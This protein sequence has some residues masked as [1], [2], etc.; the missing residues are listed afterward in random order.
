[1]TLAHT[2]NR[3]QPH[4]LAHWITK[5]N[6]EAKIRMEAAGGVGK[7]D[8][9][10]KSIAKAQT[11]KMGQRVLLKMGGVGGA[12]T[13]FQ[14]GRVARVRK[15]ITYDVQLDSGGELEIE[16]QPGRLRARAGKAGAPGK[17]LAAAGGGGVLAR[18]AT[19]RKTGGANKAKARGRSPLSKS[20]R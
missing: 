15:N 11:F 5:Q 14:P 17:Q 7:H 20:K 18:P 4:Q 12:K 9:A 6:A 19:G 16:V 3:C 8:A 10:K 13:V 2:P 1:M